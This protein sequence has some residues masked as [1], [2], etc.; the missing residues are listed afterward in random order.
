MISCGFLDKINWYY[1]KYFHLLYINLWY[2]ALYSKLTEKVIW[3][4]DLI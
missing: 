2:I 4:S 1:E 3:K